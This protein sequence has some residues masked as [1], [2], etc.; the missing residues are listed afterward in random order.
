M[1]DRD[2]VLQAV[3]RES[4][5]LTFGMDVYRVRDDMTVALVAESVAITGGSVTADSSANARRSFSATVPLRPD[6]TYH[7]VGDMTG[8]AAAVLPLDVVASHVRIYAGVGVGLSTVRVP[9]A[10]CRVDT[11]SRTNRGPLEISGPGL[12]AYVV[13]DAVTEATVYPAGSNIIGTIKSIITAAVPY[14]KFAV[15]ADAATNSKSLG[16]PLDREVGSS[17]WDAVGILANK[18]DYD[19]YCDSTGTFVIEP[20]RTLE[21]TTPVLTVDAGTVFPLP[22]APGGNLSTLDLSTTR[23]STYN[24]VV[25]TGQSSDP[26]TPPVSHVERIRSGPLRWGGPF[27]KKAKVMG[28]NPILVTKAAAAKA[29]ATYLKR[30]QSLERTLD[31]SMIPNPTL[32]PGDVVRVDML[33][34]THEKHMVKKVD[35]PF[36]LTAPWKV[37]TVSV[38]NDD[39]PSAS[40]GGNP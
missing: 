16:A 28:S 6:G 34:G 7:F 23:E 38:K 29:A 35:I 32:E 5:T 14:A 1:I 11:I 20:E 27:G 12:E 22:G 36:G 19:V 3:M 9:L 10:V 24:A 37:E 18:I 39:D 13:E 2:P 30:Y 17:P 33:D 8:T 40:A 15:T 4:Y 25:V 31:F 21:N 26:D